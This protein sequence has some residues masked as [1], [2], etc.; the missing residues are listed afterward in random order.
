M[1]CSFLADRIQETRLTTGDEFVCF[2]LFFL[3]V[4][5]GFELATATLHIFYAQLDVVLQALP[6]DILSIFSSRFVAFCF[7]WVGGV[8]LLR[9]VP[10]FSLVPGGRVGDFR[11]LLHSCI[12][13]SL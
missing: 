1:T 11:H 13:L 10:L 5:T 2:F 8:P 3:C 7:L 9:F 6:H 4:T 12:F